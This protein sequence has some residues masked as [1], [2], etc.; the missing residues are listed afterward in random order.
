MT[1]QFRPAT[2]DDADAAVPLI[3]SSGP[4]AFDYVFAVPGK[5]DSQAFL[6]RAFVD[7]RGE[8]GFRNHVIGI[9]DGR[10]V[11]AGAGWDGTATAS[12]TLAASRQIIGCYG[13]GAGTG[14]MLRGLRVEAI[15]QPPGRRC[16]YVAHLGVPPDLRSRGIGV[17][18]VEHLLDS[19]RARGHSLAAL[20]VAVTNPRAEALYAR[21][22]FRTT[23]E[24]TSLLANA[25]ATVPSHRRMELPLGAQA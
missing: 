19:G 14:V 6:R 9:E 10:V 7:G 2:P 13:L 3:Y 25:Q 4:A 15:V 8:F 16:W 17:A 23:R 12:F 21:L 1:L 5:A 22:G 20:D 11:A 24:L 18:L